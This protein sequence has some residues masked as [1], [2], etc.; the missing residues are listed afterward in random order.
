MLLILEELQVERIMPGIIAAMLYISTGGLVFTINTLSAFLLM[1]TFP[2]S[3]LALTIYEVSDT[4]V[5]ILS[6]LGLICDGCLC[7]S[8]QSYYS[9]CS[10][11]FLIQTLM[12]IPLVIS[13]FSIYGIFVKHLQD[14]NEKFY[15][16]Q[17]F[18]QTISMIW[19]GVAWLMALVFTLVLW[20]GTQ[21][22]H[23]GL[24]HDNSS[25]AVKT[26][27]R[28]S[29]NL[30]DNLWQYNSNEDWSSDYRESVIIGL[31]YG[32]VRGNISHEE[33]QRFR[34]ISSNDGI[35][36][37]SKIAIKEFHTALGIPEE[38]QKHIFNFERNNLKDDYNSTTYDV[39]QNDEKVFSIH[40]P[41]KETPKI[42]NSLKNIH[43]QEYSSGSAS[44]PLGFLVRNNNR[45]NS[46]NSVSS[47]MDKY[48]FTT[49]PIRKDT[50]SL[51]IPQQNSH[52]SL[53]Q[54]TTLNS[55]FSPHLN[56][57][58]T[59]NMTDNTGNKYQAHQAATAICDTQVIIF[60]PVHYKKLYF[61]IHPNNIIYNEG[62]LS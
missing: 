33:L 6:G 30:V 26:E 25:Y 5:A 41:I 13:H 4:L 9:S 28:N 36:N 8:N 31:I 27:T 61:Y 50:L 54:K 14:S 37:H 39:A 19:T 3:F 20:S 45:L 43:G 55:E 46:T 56:T 12:I 10:R 23:M 51:T 15:S 16:L 59:K 22:F 52:S 24:I 47:F 11:Y 60:F 53:P 17:P 34:G 38:E 2:R 57:N 58:A 18:Q 32:I 62:K 1:N 29:K 35:T 49:E 21:G 48:G 40:Y 44:N 7:L 42:K